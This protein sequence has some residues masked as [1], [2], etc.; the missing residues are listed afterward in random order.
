MDDKLPKLTFTKDE[1]AHALGVKK[2]TIEY[3]IRTKRLPHRKISR[4][5]LFTQEDLDC[6]IESSKRCKCVSIISIPIWLSILPGR[7]AVVTVSLIDVYLLTCYLIWVLFHTYLK[8]ILS[9]WYEW[10]TSSL[11]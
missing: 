7:S 2:S 6:F 3:L 8:E 5:I 1:A 10:L 11:K 4:Y 9:T